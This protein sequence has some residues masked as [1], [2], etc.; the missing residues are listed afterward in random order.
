LGL[1]AKDFRARV[2]L[3]N[4]FKHFYNQISFSRQN[5]AARVIVKSF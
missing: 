5:I 2:E 4:H 1:G 3:A